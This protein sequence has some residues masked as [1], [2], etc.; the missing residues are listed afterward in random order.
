MFFMLLY[1]KTQISQ[2]LCVVKRLG[3][4]SLYWNA[5]SSHIQFN[6]IQF[7]LFCICQIQEGSLD[8]EDIEHVS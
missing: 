7:N 1:L 5:E 3:R 4:F 6:S 2:S 8:L